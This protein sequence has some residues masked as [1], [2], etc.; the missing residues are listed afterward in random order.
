MAHRAAGLDA[1]ENSLEAVRAAKKNGARVI[2]FDVALTA[3]GHAVVFHDDTLARLTGK[4]D[5]IDQLTLE[6]V[7]KVD[8]AERHVLRDEFTPTR[9]PTLADFVAECLKHDLRM[10]IDLK[11]YLA[12]E[13][14]AKIILELFQRHADLHSKAMVS[15]FWP[16]LI[17]LVRSRDPRIICSMAWRPQF[18]AYES[19]SAV[20]GGAKRRFDGLLQHYAAV[21]GD[22]VLRWGL[23]EFLWY[24]LGLS[25][26]LVEKDYLTLGYVQARRGIYHTIKFTC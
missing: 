9:I 12:P 17:Y 14:T 23:H 13:A 21:A 10:V 20:A 15:S 25:A 16:H 3:D 7:R 24:F 19:Y 22:V 8:I 5:R 18:L 1:P 11:T 6:E 2:E 26:V 4:P